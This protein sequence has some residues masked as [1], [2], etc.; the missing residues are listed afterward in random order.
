MHNSIL[1]VFILFNYSRGAR[2]CTRAKDSYV[3]SYECVSSI[4]TLV[5]RNCGYEPSQPTHD[6][7]SPPCENSK[8]RKFKY[9]Y[10]NLILEVKTC[11]VMR[12]RHVYIC[13]L[14]VKG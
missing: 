13:L 9:S 6:T 3:M 14:W 7:S 4:Q 11:I 10:V 12:S 8:C 2:L 1:K 5:S